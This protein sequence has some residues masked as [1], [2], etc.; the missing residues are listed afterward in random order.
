MN[1]FLELVSELKSLSPYAFS[2][3]SP[4]YYWS[5][6]EDGLIGASIN[7]NAI[8]LHLDLITEEKQEWCDRLNAATKEIH[9][10]SIFT[11]VG[12]SHKISMIKELRY[13]LGLGLKEAKEAVENYLSTGRMK[14][15][16]FV[17]YSG[18]PEL[19]GYGYFPFCENQPCP[20]EMAEVLG[21]DIAE[22]KQEVTPCTRWGIIFFF[23]SYI[24]ISHFPE[25]A[26]LG[27]DGNNVITINQSV[28]SKDMLYSCGDKQ[29]AGE[30]AL[31][32]NKAYKKGCADITEKMQALLD[33]L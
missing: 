3:G 18:V 25:D 26:A 22:E 11:K 28:E 2:I 23:S 31:L 10:G 4:I 29:E 16:P 21:Y 32:L 6:D 27:W 13:A 33:N 17:L 1:N 24:V 20:I 14:P 15:L 9:N 19:E 12:C 7:S 30:I 8:S 5:V